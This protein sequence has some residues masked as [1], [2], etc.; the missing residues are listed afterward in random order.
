M[1]RW[2]A[3]LLIVVCLA[4][5]TGAL[6]VSFDPNPPCKGPFK[7]EEPTDEQLAEI[8]AIHQTW[9]DGDFQ[10][11]DE[12][13]ANLCEAELHEAE[14]T[15]A[16]LRGANLLETNLWE[17]NLWE[18]NLSGA[19]LSGANLRWA[20]LSWADLKGVDLRDTKMEDATICKTL[21]AWGEDNSGCNK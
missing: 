9:L 11:G 10:E 17:A 4:T 5:V 13:R 20:D 21:T 2:I 3:F 12:R 18:A 14:L 19:N 15:G 8:F 6:A 7:G 1:C 16:N